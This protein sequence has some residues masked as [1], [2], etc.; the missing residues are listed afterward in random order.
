MDVDKDIYYSLSQ[1][2]KKKSST[3]SRNNNIFVWLNIIKLR[4]GTLGQYILPIHI[5]S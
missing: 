1:M 5:I 3:S 2:K 4:L